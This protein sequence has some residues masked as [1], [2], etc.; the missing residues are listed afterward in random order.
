[1]KE[2]AVRAAGSAQAGALLRKAGI[3]PN[4]RRKIE[5]VEKAVASAGTPLTRRQA[6]AERR[7]VVGQ[8]DTELRELLPGG[9][10]E[11]CRAALLSCSVRFL[12]RHRGCGTECDPSCGTKAERTARVPAK[13][14]A[15]LINATERHVEAMRKE[16]LG[17]GVTTDSCASSSADS[18]A[19]V[20]Y[21]E[22]RFLCRVMYDW[23]T[24]NINETMAAALPRLFGVSRARVS[25]LRDMLCGAR[26]AGVV[27]SEPIV[28]PAC[29]RCAGRALPWRK[30]GGQHSAPF[31]RGLQV[32]RHRALCIHGWRCRNGHAATGRL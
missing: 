29:I 12:R 7:K 2:S 28:L 30:P 32:V 16:W 27:W 21:A 5:R 31:G 4:K 25:R 26:D 22:S 15:L 20:Y 13:E 23:C 19:S 3:A 11:R 1:M 24:G 14:A 9:G 8:L 6:E 17:L 18:K 10:C